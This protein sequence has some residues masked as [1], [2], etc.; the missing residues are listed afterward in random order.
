MLIIRCINYMYVCRRLVLKPR[1]SFCVIEEIS[2]H[3]VSVWL[4]VAFALKCNSTRSSH[5]FTVS[6]LV[7]HLD[8]HFPFF[9]VSRRK[10]MLMRS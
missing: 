8:E 1:I 4:G 9:S 7:D 10:M 3:Y 5:V 2:L 6:L